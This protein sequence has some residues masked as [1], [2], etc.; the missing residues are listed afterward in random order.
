[1]KAAT[2]WRTLVGDPLETQRLSHERLTKTKGLAVFSSD[3]LSSSAYATEEILHVLVLAGLAGVAFTAHIATGIVVLLAIVAISYY[4]TIHAYPS[5]GGAYIVAH[6]NLGPMPG[7]IAGA[8]L[9]V[10]YILTV[11]VSISA[12]VAAITSA[13]PALFAHRVEL[14]VG[15]VIL[16]T[17]ANLR[18][19]RESGTLFALPTYGFIA[20]FGAMVLIGLYNIATGQLPRQTVELAAAGHGHEL[21][22]LTLFLLLRAFASG[23]AALTGV[24]AVSNGI[25]AFYPPES[26]NASTVLMVMVG[27]LGVFFLG[28]SY[29]A[30]WMALVPKETETIVSQIGRGIFGGDS[31]IYYA[32]QA[33]TAMILVLAAN[34][35]YADFP[36]LTS[37]LARDRYLPR[38]LSNLGDR[39]VFANG[40][41]LLGLAGT[42]LM[43]VFK[44]RTHSLIPLYMIGVFLSFTMSQSGM[45]R[46]W[47]KERKGRWRAQ[48]AV[49]GF[50]AVCTAIVGVVVAVVKFR[51]GAWITVVVIAVVV[52]LMRA[53][54]R[55]YRDVARQLSLENLRTPEP[56][57][58][59]KVIV[60]INDVHRG[61]LEAI[62][63]AKVLGGEVTAVYV[64]IDAAR[65][66][67]IERKW[68]Q[69]VPDVPLVVLPSPY[70]SIVSPI[71]M[72]LDHIHR[73]SGPRGVITVVLPEFVPRKWW[74]HLL[75]NQSALMLK[76][77][78][79]FRARRH[80]RYK[81]LADVPYYLHR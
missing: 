45:V 54:S 49:N 68:E 52:L 69:W 3:A 67:D 18:G 70:R 30:K 50:G 25:P 33:S 81:V 47:L 13:L 35:A 19:V 17:L 10:D 22:A 62:R 1:V 15:F 42:V 20:T 36:R 39:L 14:A 57:Q 8:A 74:H 46:H 72:Y 56:F 63:Y 16:I 2:V 61:I 77:A 73:E 28:T 65:R 9:L 71:L 78:L 37:I 31:W 12:G 59:H 6:E 64:E 53:V 41:L 80:G 24:E 38:Q 40:I 60:P 11:A 48:L 5:G 27:V 44:A 66:A 43:I 26:R 34:T 75:H 4:Q 51:E 76:L 58:Y 55:H 21:Q 79:L 7:L 23:A 32:I 29:L